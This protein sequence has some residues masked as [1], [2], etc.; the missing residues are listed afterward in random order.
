MRENIVKKLKEQI[1]QKE[2]NKNN[3]DIPKIEN[4]ELLHENI[5]IKDSNI[6]SDLIEN[7]P[8]VFYTALKRLW[9]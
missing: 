8:E 2:L 6:I 9:F 7:N 4:L 3:I 5:N 1:V